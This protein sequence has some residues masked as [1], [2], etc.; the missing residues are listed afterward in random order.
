MRYFIFVLIGLFLLSSGCRNGDSEISQRFEDGKKKVI[1]RFTGTGDMR[2]LVGRTTYNRVGQVTLVENNVEKTRKLIRWH[3]NG[4][5]KSEHLYKNGKKHGKWCLWYSNG[6][7]KN[8]KVFDD[9]IMIRESTY[10]KNTARE[11][12]YKNGKLYIDRLYKKG[13]LS[14][15]K[16]YRDG[17]VVKGR[18]F[19]ADGNL[20][21]E[22]EY[23]DSKKHGRFAYWDRNGKLRKEI[24]YEKGKLPEDVTGTNKSQFKP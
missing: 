2:K 1:G 21:D 10:L 4:K 14:V 6:R 18:W 22:R 20:S 9:G 17:A 8:V 7:I 16:I 13:N 24:L 5:R 23:K 11:V 19:Y 15:E 3:K 12:I